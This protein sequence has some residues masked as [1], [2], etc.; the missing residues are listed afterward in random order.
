MWN[1]SRQPGQ[2]VPHNMSVIIHRFI[3]ISSVSTVHK[4]THNLRCG[5]QLFRNGPVLNLNLAL[6]NLASELHCWVPLFHRWGKVLLLGLYLILII[7]HVALDSVEFNNAGCDCFHAS[8]A[9]GCRHPLS[10]LGLSH[11]WGALW[12]NQL[13]ARSSHQTELFITANIHWL[14][15]H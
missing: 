6:G 8:K 13:R 1:D 3:F 9:H 5:N 12:K 4:N 7:S 11:K 10:L 2:G 14:R 15:S